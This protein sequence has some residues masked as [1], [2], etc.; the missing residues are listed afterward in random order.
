M[1]IQASVSRLRSLATSL[2]AVAM[3]AGC[4]GG[5]G[6]G[7]TSSAGGGV[8]A[9]RGSVSIRVIWPADPS[10]S[11][12][13]IPS[14][15]QS[16]TFSVLRG[17]GAEVEQTIVLER[18]E[19]EARFEQLLEGPVIVQA[20]A[21]P[22][23]GGSGTALA[24][25]DVPVT[26]VAAQ[27]TTATINL[28]STVASFSIEPGDVAAM[29]LG[30]LTS[31]GAIGRDIQGAIVLLPSATWTAEGDAVEIITGQSAGEPVAAL[32]AGPGT[33]TLRASVEQLQ[34]D[35][36]TALVAETTVAVALPDG[37]AD[38][39]A[40]VA[41]A[42]QPVEV[43]F[44]GGYTF[45]APAGAFEDGAVV[46]VQLSEPL[47]GHEWAPEVTSDGRAIG[48][49]ADPRQWL[50][51]VSM[52][53][54]GEPQVDGQGASAPALVGQQAV[55]LR[56]PSPSDVTNSAGSTTVV[57]H[58]DSEET[59]WLTGSGRSSTK[60]KRPGTLLTDA[61]LLYLVYVRSQAVEPTSMLAPT[62][63]WDAA[64]QEWL[65]GAA[66]APWPASGRVAI[67]IPGLTATP[68]FL[69]QGATTPVM[70]QGL[71]DT[72]GTRIWAYSYNWFGPLEE[73]AQELQALLTQKGAQPKQVDL[74]CHSMGGLVARQLVE[75]AG[76]DSYVDRVVMIGTPHTGTPL[77]NDIDGLLH[78]CVAT[79]N[80]LS[81][82]VRAAADLYLRLSLQGPRQLRTDSAFL[83]QLNLP[84]S[85]PITA[86]YFAIAG[87]EDLPEEG[88]ELFG[89]YQDRYPA[90]FFS[91]RGEPSDWLV[92]VASAAWEG[93]ADQTSATLVS[94]LL[95][96]SHTD[97]EVEG[98]D[99]RYWH[100]ELPFQ[101]KTA[102]QLAAW[103]TREPEPPGGEGSPWLYNAATH[104]WYCRTP[105]GLTWPQAQAWAASNGGYLATIN[106]AAENAW[107]SQ[108]LL[109]F[110]GFGCF[111][112]LREVSG[113]GDWQWVNGDPLNYSNWYSG[114][115]NNHVGAENVVMVYAIWNK[116]RG[117][118][119]DTRSDTYGTPPE[120]LN[121]GIVERDTTPPGYDSGRRVIRAILDHVEPEDQA[122]LYF[123]D[124]AGHILA[125]NS[126][127]GFGGRVILT[128]LPQ[129]NEDVRVRVEYS[130]QQGQASGNQIPYQ[131]K[132]SYTDATNIATANLTGTL[133]YSTH[134]TDWH[135]PYTVRASQNVKFLR[136]RLTHLEPEDQAHLLLHDLS[137]NIV[138]QNGYGGHGG[139][140][141][142]LWFAPSNYDVRLHVEYSTQ[143]G[144][145]SG[146]HIPYT[147]DVWTT[148]AAGLTQTQVSGDL[149]YSSH[150]TDWF[151]PYELR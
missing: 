90:H 143:Q 117:T 26:V 40:W 1:S 65:P 134:N 103:L 106:D 71:S 49:A 148:G 46:A 29:Q 38:G 17:P 98:E 86:R 136:A 36:G 35:P 88:D 128:Y 62:T 25:T 59:S 140:V 81:Y 32:A 39:Q 109:D 8:P 133:V 99:S 89:S 54:P 50:A 20:R 102:Q 30:D 122:H 64:E 56:L 141:E 84:P 16:L 125:S 22:E 79:G 68:G 100:N 23:P 149:V 11:E 105:A 101:P 124:T 94:D 112:G 44:S 137:G 24:A 115:P 3:V 78:L 75:G 52:S 111:I 45:A 145:A 120:T 27:T 69:L 61:V 7:G 5:G 10:R 142:L 70:L 77:A 43:A 41:D 126:Y 21:F 18:P 131:L 108:Y 147:I 114:E 28:D 12:R 72:Y 53:L 82:P 130:T 119:N 6:N 80:R 151:G 91:E 76:G 110:T 67:I 83:N 95:T 138:A 92:P 66:A 129:T 150:N 4:G 60:L 123:Y 74:I 127:N 113:E 33:A 14:L 34:G 63:E 139:P 132:V 15:T 96:L 37:A 58:P 31:L 51:P 48:L 116:T 87:N 2:L 144:S 146:N 13:L 135:G 47:A 73:A 57:L 93:L 55:D 42:T 85:L 104:H 118:W 9:A 107:V 121:G 19:T 97:P